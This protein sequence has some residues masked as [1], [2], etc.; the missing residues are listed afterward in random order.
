MPRATWRSCDGGLL[1]SRMPRPSFA[2]P[3]RPRPARRTM[4]LSFRN[5][6]MLARSRG[7]LEPLRASRA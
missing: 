1:L 5:C 2:R 7:P 6:R 3:R 4:V